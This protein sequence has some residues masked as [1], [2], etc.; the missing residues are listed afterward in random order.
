MSLVTKTLKNVIA[1][2]CLG[3]DRIKGKFGEF[4]NISSSFLFLFK[5][6]KTIN[7]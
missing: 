1:N 4:G 7:K 5:N 2:K 3:Q 6:R